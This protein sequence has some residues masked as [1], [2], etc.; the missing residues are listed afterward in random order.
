MRCICCDRNLNDYE[1]TR[2]HAVTGDY[3]DI[4]NKCFRD[5]SND[6]PTVAR[7]DLAYTEQMEQDTFDTDWED[8]EE[9]SDE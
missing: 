9:N 3:L 2:K 6:V 5:I 7:S 4:C 1:T 8:L